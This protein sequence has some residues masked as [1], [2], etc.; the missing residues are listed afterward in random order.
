MILGI[1]AA[2]LITPGLL[3]PLRLPVLLEEPLTHGKLVVM[4]L[5]SPITG[6][7]SA[8]PVELGVLLADKFDFTGAV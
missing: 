3:P 1:V 7:D 8:H 2:L 5:D 6:G 4:E